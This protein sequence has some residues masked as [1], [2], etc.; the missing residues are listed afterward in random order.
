LLSIS[1]DKDA[2]ALIEDIEMD[3]RVAL[4]SL[5]RQGYQRFAA[6]DWTEYH[7]SGEQ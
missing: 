6:G 1:D 2:E 7:L 3:K 5:A 4:K